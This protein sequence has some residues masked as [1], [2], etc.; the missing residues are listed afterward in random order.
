MHWLLRRKVLI[1]RDA[2]L[3]LSSALTPRLYV[4]ATPQA[5]GRRKIDLAA[6]DLPSSF[7]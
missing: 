1:Y 5:V 7:F 6:I 2:I 4:L 3:V